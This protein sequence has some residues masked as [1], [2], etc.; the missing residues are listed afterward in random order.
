MNSIQFND[1]ETRRQQRNLTNSQK[2]NN[3]KMKEGVIVNSLIKDGE[4][5]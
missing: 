4:D 5:S 3:Y 2:L 1:A